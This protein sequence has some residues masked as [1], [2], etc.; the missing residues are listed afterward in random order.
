MEKK[1]DLFWLTKSIHSFVKSLFSY[2]REKEKEK[3]CEGE[4]GRGV[5]GTSERGGEREILAHEMKM[6][7]SLVN[8]AH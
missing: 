6:V 5:R 8:T 1:L 4:C 3:E 7:K 2:P